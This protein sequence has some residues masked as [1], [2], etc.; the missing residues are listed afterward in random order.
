M[1]RN[2]AAR[3]LPFGGLLN[4]NEFCGWRFS[5]VKR[6]PFQTLYVALSEYLTRGFDSNQGLANWKSCSFPKKERN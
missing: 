5:A 6:F 4:S 3:E 1:E 2:T